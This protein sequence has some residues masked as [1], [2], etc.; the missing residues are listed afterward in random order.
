[1]EDKINY[2]FISLANE[3]GKQTLE[4][5]N[6]RN[7]TRRDTGEITT[8]IQLTF[9]K[10]KKSFLGNQMKHRSISYMMS[11]SPANHNKNISY[12]LKFE[13]IM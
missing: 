3:K 11:T 1:M 13:G 8:T 2:P 12:F 9:K 10:K 6:S 4:S 7:A 5:R